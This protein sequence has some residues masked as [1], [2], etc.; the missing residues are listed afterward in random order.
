MNVYSLPL[1]TIVNSRIFHPCRIVSK[2]S[3]YFHS[4]I[5]HPCMTVPIFP[6]PHFP[7]LQDRADISTPA[8]STPAGPCQCFHSRIF[9]HCIFDR[10]DFSTPAFSVAPIYRYLHSVICTK[11]DRWSYLPINLEQIA[12]D[13]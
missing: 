4:R 9:H 11:L 6:L 8:I 12:S 1:N 13:Q 7:P 2:S 5:F 3:R 10:A